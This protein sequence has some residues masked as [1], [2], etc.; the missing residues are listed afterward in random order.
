MLGSPPAAAPG[1]QGRLTT[2]GDAPVA[3]VRRQEVSLFADGVGG[4]VSSTV[5]GPWAAGET[6]P[7]P[8][9][10]AALLMRLGSYSPSRVRIPESPRVEPVCM[11][12][13][14]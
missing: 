10:G 6:S 14:H 1:H 11:L 9:Y 13:E 8:V 2:P 7:S 3:G 5:G 12:A 4:T